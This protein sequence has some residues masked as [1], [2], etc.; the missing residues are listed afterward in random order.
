MSE[1]GSKR[2]SMS[3]RGFWLVAGGVLL[4]GV[5]G[6]LAAIRH[7][8]PEKGERSPVVAVMPVIR[9]D[10]PVTLGSLGTITAS[11]TVIIRSRVDGQLE[12]LH[13]AD[14]QEVRAGQLLAELDPRPFQ[15]QLL[16]AQGQLQKDEALLANARLDLAR[17]RQ[18]QQQDS[19]A[20]QQVETQAALVRQYEGTVKIDQGLVNNAQLQLDYSRITA[21]FSGRLGIRQVDPG[22]L[23]HA[24][25]TS[26]LV[27][28]TRIRPINVAFSVPETRL[29]EVTAAMNTVGKQ[30]LL[31]EVWDRDRHARLGTGRLLA[32]DN[33][34]NTANGS[35]AI[36]GELANEDGSLFPNQFVNVSLR[37]GTLSGATV[38]PEAAVQ[39]GRD[40][41]YVY[42]VQAGGNAAM[43]PVR[44]LH[45]D[46]ER[47]AVAGDVRPGE[48]VIVDGLDKVRDGQKVKV[49][50]EHRQDKTHGKKPA[51]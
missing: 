49:A 13:F 47:M 51:G 28:M 32:L 7:K 21:P 26:G 5:I 39:T 20:R 19:I 34:V 18:L 1:S 30:P 40:G 46:G 41:S 22:N 10:M 25:D 8:T 6:G 29:R 16:Q 27:S 15:A 3:K 17:Y 38:V 12:K 24:A 45:K 31:I 23:I 36:K 14:G 2:I 50:D 37:L 9:M 35:V 11:Q 48:R 44:M 43:K 33:Q 42:V 4:A